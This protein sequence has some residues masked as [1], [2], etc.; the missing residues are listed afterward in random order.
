[1]QISLSSQHNKVG[2]LPT[3]QEKQLLQVHQMVRV[4]SYL[5]D[6]SIGRQGEKIEI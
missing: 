2:Q 3:N 4:G 5:Y 1:M 6:A